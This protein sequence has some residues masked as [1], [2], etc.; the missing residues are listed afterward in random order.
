MIDSRSGSPS[1]ECF[2]CPF[3]VRLTLFTSHSSWIFESPWVRVSLQV[4]QCPHVS[5]TSLPSVD[6]LPRNLV[7]PGRGRVMA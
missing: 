4:G 2:A 6:T 1:V 7:E 5:P 3:T